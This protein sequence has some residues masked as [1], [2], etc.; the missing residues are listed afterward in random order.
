MTVQAA[1]PT[2]D[3]LEIKVFPFGKRF[4]PS[5]CNILFQDKQGPVTV[6]ALCVNQLELVGCFKYFGSL[7]TQGGDVGNKT[8]SRIVKAFY[9]FFFS[10]HFLC[11]FNITLCSHLA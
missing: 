10:I 8:S 5:R 4:A 11:S 1:Q 6:F 3:H 9:Y 7:I 2:L